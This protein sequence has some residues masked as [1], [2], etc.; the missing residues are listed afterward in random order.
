MAGND[1]YHLYIYGQNSRW[2]KYCTKVKEL[3]LVS[4]IV[5]TEN[6]LFQTLALLASV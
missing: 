4:I 5:T 2:V 6:L 3:M 1:P